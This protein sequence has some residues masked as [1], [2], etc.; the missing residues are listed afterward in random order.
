MDASGPFWW[1]LR[2][3]HSQAP[4]HLPCPLCSRLAF[5]PR[6]VATL[7]VGGGDGNGS[8]QGGLSAL[9][10]GPLGGTFSSLRPPPSL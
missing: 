1:Q 7:E 6:A 10:P 8:S 5:I 4:G 2:S 9:P 3:Q